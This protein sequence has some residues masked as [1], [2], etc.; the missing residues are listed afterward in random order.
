MSG[1]TG[2]DQ[3]GPGD[4]DVEATLAQLRREYGGTDRLA[5]IAEDLERIEQERLAHPDPPPPSGR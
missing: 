2:A 3:Q 1:P 5:E 4:L